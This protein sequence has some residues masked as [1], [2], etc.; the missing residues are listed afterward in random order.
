ML[1]S[2]TMLFL[3][4]CQNASIEHDAKSH[5]RWYCALGIHAVE[6]CKHVSRWPLQALFAGLP[7][8]LGRRLKQGRHHVTGALGFFFQHAPADALASDVRLVG[9]LVDEVVHGPRGGA[10]AERVA[11]PLGDLLDAL[12][13]ALQRRS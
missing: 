2:A 7:I 13:A 11:H 4:T 9:V 8:A 5:L 1:L 3:T 12:V 6:R 10:P